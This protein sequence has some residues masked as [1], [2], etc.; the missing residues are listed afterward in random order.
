M[1]LVLVRKGIRNGTLFYFLKLPF[2]QIELK[3]MNGP[4]HTLFPLMQ[5]LR[6]K[7]FKKSL[8][9]IKNVISLYHKTKLYN[10][11]TTLNPIKTKKLV[12]GK[13]G[14]EVSGWLKLRDGSKTH[15]TIDKDGEWEQW[16]NST[17][18]LCLTVNFVENLR[19]FL[20]YG[21]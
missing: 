6:K 10:M 18:N 14:K 8:V 19:N 4:S 20:L 2:L 16:G 15:F 13:K 3:I 7:K 21:E 9:G 1:F 5:H 17:D 11:V 12:W